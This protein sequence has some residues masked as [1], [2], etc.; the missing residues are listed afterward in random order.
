MKRSLA[1]VKAAFINMVCCFIYVH[2]IWVGF[3]MPGGIKHAVA[4]G[5]IQN[6][7]SYR[8]NSQCRVSMAWGI[9]HAMS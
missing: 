2:T 4:P 6:F 8:S 5:L 9:N 1:M 7:H 3:E